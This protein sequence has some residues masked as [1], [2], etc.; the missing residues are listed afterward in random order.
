MSNE[1]YSQPPLSYETP[2]FPSLYWP[3]NAAPS[4]PQYLYSLHDIWRFTLYWTLITVLAAHFLVSLVAVISQFVTAY[5]RHRFLRSQEGK[6]LTPK[7]RKLFG[8]KPLQE[9][10]TWVWL[11]PLIYLTIGG[12]EALLGGSIVGLVLG[13]VYNSG[14]FRMRSWEECSMFDELIVKAH[15]RFREFSWRN[16]AQPTKA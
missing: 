2:G 11:V 6:K 13:A 1:L 10:A 7:N 9:C 3:F 15:Q 8:E 16:L 5:S 4:A 12:L 14:Y